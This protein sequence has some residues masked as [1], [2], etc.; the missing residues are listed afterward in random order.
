[1]DAKAW[2]SLGSA[3]VSVLSLF[4]TII[5]SVWASKSAGRA[6]S[7][8]V[9]A[10]ETALRQTISVTRQ[11]VEDLAVQIGSL[12]DG[13]RDDQLNA[14]DN[15][16]C[17]PLQKAFCSAVEDNLIWLDPVKGCFGFRFSL[18]GNASSKRGGVLGGMVGDGGSA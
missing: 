9:G 10:A 14:Q 11:R 7:I 17:A 1:M 16:R 8:T 6:Q 4:A 13:R 18:H 3:V 12:L 5:F 15:R 2:I